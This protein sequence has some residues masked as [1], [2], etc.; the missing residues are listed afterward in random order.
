VTTFKTLSQ[1]LC[2]ES[3]YD[4]T[5]GRREREY[6]GINAKARKRR[7]DAKKRF[8]CLK[9]CSCCSCCCREARRKQSATDKSMTSKSN[10]NLNSQAGNVNNDVLNHAVNV[11]NEEKAKLMET[12]LVDENNNNKNN[13]QQQSSAV[14]SPNEEAKLELDKSDNKSNNV[15]GKAGPE[16]TAT[17]TA[18]A[19]SP[20]S[21]SNVNVINVQMFSENINEFDYIDLD[22]L[23]KELNSSEATPERRSLMLAKYRSG[24]RNS[25]VAGVSSASLD[26][27]MEL[28][29]EMLPP[30]PPV[31]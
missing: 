3:V 25:G 28:H 1:K 10:L 17:A 20:P 31:K 19:Q 4:S 5:F 7:N 16:A 8:S 21:A 6:L 11:N 30:P 27:N 12:G 23:T 29:L 22:V 26:P 24:L 14:R 9:C 2:P 15:Y 13:N 18:T